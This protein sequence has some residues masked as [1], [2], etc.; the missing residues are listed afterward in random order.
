MAAPGVLEHQAP[1]K[2]GDLDAMTTRRVVRV[3]V[4]YSRTLFFNDRGAQRGL[5]ADTLRD[6]EA[7]LN[8][9][10]P[11]KA[12]PI[13]VLAIPT[14]RERLLPALLEG[15]GDIAA[16]NLTI[17]PEREAQVAFSKP[18]A[19]D[20]AEIV[21]TGPR[22]PKLAVLEDL[23]GHDVHVRKSSSYYGSLLALNS[24]LS[25]AGKP[26]I[27]VVAVP[28]VL[29]D[30]DLMDMLAAGLVELTV[31]DG[32]KAK[33]WARL[34]KRLKP[35]ADL[36]LTAGQNVG[37]AFRR[38]SPKLAAVID[39]FIDRYPGARATR[40]RNYPAYIVQLRNATADA[41]WKRFQSEIALF[42][43]YA[44][45]YGV[46]PLMAAAL[47]YQES[48]L[49]QNA[50]SAVGA[51]GVMQLMPDTGAELKV[52]DISQL[53]PNIHG[54]IKYLRNLRERAVT[55]GSPDEQNQMLFALAAYNCG[56]GR[57]AELRAEA[58]KRGLDPDL[59]F[60]N[61]E[62]V[63]ARRVGQETV[64]YVRNIYK[65]YVAYKLQLETLEARKAA[66]KT[67]APAR[68]PQEQRP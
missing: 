67:L 38:G 12:H 65:Y 33:I 59:W 43:K 39:E 11:K 46:D 56:P 68:P 41:D 32:W 54:G 66:A 62:L 35:R 20:S 24:R 1:E 13:V 55:G 2:L 53:E 22:S 4:P 27:R 47:G 40:F 8:K 7:F 25:A 37:W 18:V 52:G 19:I 63:A 9:K 14:T 61:V 48:R 16:G 21:V 42:R 60:D 15:R 23:G 34:Q 31:V 6:F 29:E 44:P 10:Y 50:R 58:P 64:L 3:L 49:D 26:P 5:T 36:A 30:E 51:I 17:T 28:E 45:R 57:V